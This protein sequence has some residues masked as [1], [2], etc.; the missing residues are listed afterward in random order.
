MIDGLCH[1][2]EGKSDEIV[3]DL[4]AKMQAAPS[5]GIL[6]RRPSTATSS[7]PSSGSSSGKRSSRRPWPTRT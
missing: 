5:A 7:T 4:E 6:S 3:A 2:L 1:F